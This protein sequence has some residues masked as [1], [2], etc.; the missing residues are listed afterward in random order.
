MLIGSKVRRDSS[1]Y[2]WHTIKNRQ[3]LKTETLPSQKIRFSERDQFRPF[4]EEFRES[5]LGPIPAEMLVIDLLVHAGLCDPLEANR[6]I[7]E[8][9]VSVNGQLCLSTTK[10]VCTTLAKVSV[11]GRPLEDC[12]TIS[13][14]VNKPSQFICTARDPFLRPS[15]FQ[16]LPNPQWY[17]KPI[18]IIDFASSGLIILSKSSYRLSEDV[19]QVWEVDVMGGKELGKAD[20]DLI[21]FENPVDIL[22]ESKF[23]IKTKLPSLQ[24]RIRSALAGRKLS[25]HRVSVGGWSLDQLGLEGKPGGVVA[26]SNFI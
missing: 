21:Q 26:I 13:F 4:S 23:R 8:G 22:G 15:V 17:Y 24:K 7:H 1:A 19:E 16:F 5:V 25:F 6:L 9:E 14:A 2:M 12:V 11:A 20:L 10:T 18:D 3:A